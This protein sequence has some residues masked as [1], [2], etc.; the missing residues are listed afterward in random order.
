[1]KRLIL[2]LAV[3]N[4]VG[5]ATSL[6]ANEGEELE[7]FALN[8]HMQNLPKVFLLPVEPIETD[9]P[10]KKEST[11]IEVVNERSHARREEDLPVQQSVFWGVASASGFATAD[12]L[13]GWIGIS[14]YYINH[15]YGGLMLAIVAIIGFLLPYSTSVRK[16]AFAKHAGQ[17]DSSSGNEASLRK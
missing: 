7:L 3:L 11:R 2:A 14:D 9:S 6:E 12:L 5:V 15:S 10:A 1:M 17:P 4:L 16:R 8:P 13:L